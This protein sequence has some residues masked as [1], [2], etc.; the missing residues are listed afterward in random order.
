MPWFPLLRLRTQLDASVH[1]TSRVAASA[2]LT[3]V[4]IPSSQVTVDSETLISAGGEQEWAPF[5]VI[6]LN[7]TLPGDANGPGPILD[8]EPDCWIG[9]E[10]PFSYVLHFE[11]VPRIT[12]SFGFN[13][14][15]PAGQIEEPLTKLII[16]V[17]A[18]STGNAVSRFTISATLL[19]R[20]L[21]DGTM[22][23][24]SVA[25]C[26]GIDV[27]TCRQFFI[28]PM[29]SYDILELRLE[30]MGD[31]LTTTTNGVV[32]SNG[33]RGL[34]GHFYVGA[35]AT[36]STPPPL[37]F[38]A[39]RPITNVTTSVEV[40]YFC[41][42]APQAGTYTIAV[43][44]GAEVDG[45]F[46]AELLSSAAEQTIGAGVPRQGRGRYRLHVRH[47]QFADGQMSSLDS[48]PGCLG[49]GQVRN[50]SLT[51]AGR[52]D[53]HLYVEMSGGN[54]TSLRA[55]CSGCEWVEAK[56]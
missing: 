21:L 42:L 36:L 30:R 41:T 22:I 46:G 34:V 48:R 47:A 13:H 5:N 38:D 7:G 40:E 3:G 24:S 44:P 6:L 52:H 53:A 56:P 49:F 2:E 43:V 54:A 23:D 27:D 16:G 29:Q 50:Y 33:G 18:D 25:P 12:A 15:A 28:V 8:G 11:E 35:P 31:N 17:R 20:I 32:A 9:Q 45:G 14:S 37:A 55:R 51:S 10:C 4:D 1:S 19:P 39:R 26:S